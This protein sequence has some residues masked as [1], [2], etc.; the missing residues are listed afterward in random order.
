MKPP[1]RQAITIISIITIF[2]CSSFCAAAT[3]EESI[4]Q[5]MKEFGAQSVGIYFE[6]FN[7]KV[8]TYNADEIFHAA[9]T[10]KV[11]VMMEVF[12]QVEQRTLKLDQPVFVKNEF[13]SIMDGSPYQ[14]S[15]DD[16]SDAELY[17]HVGQS[18]L[19]NELMQRMINQSSN[20]ANNLIIQI[21]TPEKVAKLMHEI[22]ADQMHVLRGVEDQKAFDAGKNNTTSARALATCLKSIMNP[23]YFQESSR[24]QMVAILLSQHDRDAVPAGVLSIDPNLKVANKDGWIDGINHDAGIIQD[25]HGHTAYLVVLTRGVKEEAQGWG[26]IANLASLLWSSHN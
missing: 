12:H 16:D 23:K 5:K 13:K 17:S 14:L 15:K 22:G 18:L 21:V 19:L 10:M 9:S 1:G 24:K 25:D 6:D 11:P 7:G 20:L 3:I 2:I 8:F 26:L 4:Q